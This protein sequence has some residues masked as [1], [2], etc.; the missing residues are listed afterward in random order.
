MSTPAVTLREIT[1]DTVRAVIRLETTEHQR[2]FVAPNAVS[3]SQAYFEPKAWFRA[4]YAGD[5]PVGF[6]MTYEDPDEPQYYLWRLM[7]AAEHQGEGYGW[8]AMQQLIDRVRGLPNAT[9]LLTSYVPGEGSPM[10]FYHR[11][12]FVD[13]G[14]MEGDE[15][16][17]ALEL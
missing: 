5:D 17:C 3:I 4:I 12:G 1:K 15:V 9:R 13:T 14:E 11:L 8:A 16:V 2:S 6:V 7:I 10:G